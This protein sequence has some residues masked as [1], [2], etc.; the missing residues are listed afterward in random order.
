[1]EDPHFVYHLSVYVY[2]GFFYLFAITLTDVM[3]ICVQVFIYENRFSILLGMRILD[4]MVTPS[5]AF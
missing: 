4:Y 1:M 5:L 3:N 2:L